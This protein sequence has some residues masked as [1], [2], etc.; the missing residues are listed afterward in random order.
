MSSDE[1]ARSE[2]AVLEPLT[3]LA[4]DA[5][6][7]L[8]DE[9]SVRGE[10]ALVARLSAAPARRSQFLIGVA[11]VAAAA[12]GGLLLGTGWKR[13]AAGPGPLSYR[14]ET[15]GS[16]SAPPV[17]GSATLLRFSDGTQVQV[18]AGTQA[19]VRAVSE[20]GATVAMASGTLH[21]D[22]IH[23]A[24]SEW[25][26]DAGPFTVHVT[27][28]AF[29]LAW[30]PAQDRFDLRLERGAVTVTTPVANDAISLRGGQWLTVRPHSN[31]VF[32]RDLE[33]P[34]EPKRALSAPASSVAA[35]A[36]PPPEVDAAARAVV[37]PKLPHEWARDLARGR[38]EHI[39]ADAQRLGMDRS[40]EESS[41]PELAALADAARYTRHDEIARAAM[42]TER[43]RF[44]G[45]RRSVDAGLL[46]GRLAEAERDDRQALRW[47][48]TYLA[49]AP[50]GPYA[51]EAL[52]RKMAIVRRVSGGA[53][54]QPIAKDYLA[55]YRD[56]TYAAAA[57]AI[58]N[59]P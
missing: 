58:L 39:I 27:G 50:T 35:N 34:S 44:A 24:S 16:A 33:A 30:E 29:Q 56:G 3:E 32:I 37:A 7:H 18:G 53:A 23:S 51:S 36:S 48:D 49:E 47:F 41:A 20:H 38:A 6:G 14:V 12:I 31:E 9:Q 5:L 10:A 59:S 46:L 42:L 17:S 13:L 57:R 54:A 11:V 22:V 15:E 4:R 28:T 26:F 45:S 25:H 40:L 52:G 19:Q 2:R 21:A 8:S 1:L 43:R 55:R